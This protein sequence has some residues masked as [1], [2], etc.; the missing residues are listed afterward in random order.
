MFYL[1]NKFQRLII[2]RCGETWLGNTDGRTHTQ[3]DYRIPRG[4]AH[5]GIIKILCT[6][7]ASENTTSAHPPFVRWKVWQ[8]V[9]S[10]TQWQWARKTTSAKLAFVRQ[11]SFTPLYDCWQ[12]T[13]TCVLW[14]INQHIL[15]CLLCVP[16]SSVTSLLCALV[17]TGV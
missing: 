8:T 3:D 5:R 11:H 1:Q 2:K 15:C 9:V 16:H 13:C 4:S 12:K 14:I 17:L 10:I 6:T 7:I